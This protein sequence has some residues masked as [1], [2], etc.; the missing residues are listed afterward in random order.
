MKKFIIITLVLLI[1]IPTAIGEFDLSGM[2]Y[3]ELVELKDKINIAI[4]NSQE[5]Q[6]VTVPQGMWRVGEDIPAGSWTVHCAIDYYG[7]ITIGDELDGKLIGYS[8][9]RESQIVTSPNFKY[10]EKG[11]DVSEYSFTVRNGDYISIDVCDMVFTPYTG[12]PD[13]GFK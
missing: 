11:K 9:R 1:I 7:M 12:K 6:E 4:W 8:S 13:L 2:S 3:K 5:W 10:F